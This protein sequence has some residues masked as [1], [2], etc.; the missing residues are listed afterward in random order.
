M[1]KVIGI[2]VLLVGLLVYIVAMMEI[3]TRLINTPWWTQVVFYTVAGVAWA[4]PLK[5]LM[6]WMHAPSRKAK[7]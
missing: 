3:G 1:R 4:L 6:A 5:P 7:T 2:I